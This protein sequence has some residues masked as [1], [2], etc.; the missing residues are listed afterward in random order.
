MTDLEHVIREKYD[1]DAS[2]VTDADRSR[3]AS[4]EP[5]AYIIGW[6]PFLGLKI[7]LDSKPLI[8][9]P[10]TEWWT[11]ILISHIRE[12]YQDKPSTVLDLCAGSGAIGL[13]VLY[14]LPETTVRFIEQEHTHLQTIQKNMQA[15][16]VSPIHVSLFSGD[17]LENASEM[18]FNIIACNPP[19]VPATRTLEASVSDFEPAH[20]LYAGKDGL[21]LIRRIAAEAPAYILPDGELWLEADISNIEEAKT[22]LETHGAKKTVIRNDHYDRPRLVIAYY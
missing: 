17:L 21:D 20:A 19:Y 12:Q 18:Q 8:P 22:L 15:N 4:G 14:S 1:G 3:L 10:E 2:H 16:N 9:R 13:A 5:L 11:E 6:V 7:Y